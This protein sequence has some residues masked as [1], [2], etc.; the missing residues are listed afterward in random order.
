MQ[1][2]HLRT[3]NRDHAYQLLA[4]GA[5]QDETAA[6]LG[7]THQRVS[8]YTKPAPIQGPRQARPPNIAL[9]VHTHRQRIAVALARLQ[10]WLG[11]RGN[12]TECWTWKGPRSK[13]GYGYTPIGTWAHREAWERAYQ[14]T[15]PKGLCVCH[16]CDNPPCVN[17][18]HLFLATY[19][20]NTQDAI[21]KGRWN[22][23]APRRPG[24]CQ[25]GHA[26]FGTRSNGSRYCRPCRAAAR[27]RLRARRG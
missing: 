27:K 7:V 22:H 11:L 19:R 18:A 4:L 21:A 1:N 9:L 25:Y 6:I 23:H 16:R 12:A 20:E 17:P 15:I 13:G 24:K 2:Q 14:A 5:N 10:P 26:D 3:S 8:Q